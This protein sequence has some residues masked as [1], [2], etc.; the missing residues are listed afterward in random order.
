MIEVIPIDEEFGPGASCVVE[1]QQILNEMHN[2]ML[3]FGRRSM[4]TEVDEMIFGHSIKDRNGGR[5]D[6]LRIEEAEKI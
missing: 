6:P 2:E 5:V 4:I 1:I 3:E